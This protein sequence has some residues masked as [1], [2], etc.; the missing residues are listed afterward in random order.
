[1]GNARNLKITSGNKAIWLKMRQKTQMTTR[2]SKTTKAAVNQFAKQK[3]QIKKARIK[4]WKQKFIIEVALEL[5]DIKQ[6][7]K[8]AM[9]IQT[10]SF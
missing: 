6:A 3:L 8:K 2:A 4:D 5:E 10:K 7:Y 9:E 1:M